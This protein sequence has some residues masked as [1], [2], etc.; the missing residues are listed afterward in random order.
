VGDSSVIGFSSCESCG[1]SDANAMYS[2]GHSYCFSCGKPTKANNGELVVIEKKSKDLI[3]TTPITKSTRGI[4]PDTFKFWK[5]HEGEFSGQRVHVANHYRKN[6]LVGQKIRMRGKDFRVL[7]NLE[8]LYGMWLWPKGS[9]KK[10]VITEGEL[11]A[12]SVSQVQANKWPVVSVPNGASGASR[13]IKDALDYLES[14]SEIVL[15]FDN[16][17]PGI[18]AAE[19][20]A[21]LFSPGKC[22]IAR[23]PEKDANDMLVSGKAAELTRAIWN[24]EAY[25]PHGIVTLADV[26]D[27]VLI[28]VEMGYSYPWQGLTDLTFGRRL[29]E[30]LFIGAGTGVGKTTFVLEMLNHDAHN[31]KLKTGIIPLEQT[32]KK[33]FQRLAGTLGNKK[34]HKPSD[35]S[36]DADTLRDTLALMNS[37]NIFVYDSKGS[38]DWDDIK[39]MIRYLALGAGCT[40]I[41]LDNI[42]GLRGASGEKN[43]D[44]ID[45]VSSDIA[46]LV[47]EL[48]IMLT[49]VSHLATPESGSHEEGARVKLR[50]FKGSRTLAAEAHNALGLERN[51]QDET[52]K[53]VTTVRV[54]KD[55]EMGEA[56]GQTIL[57]KY[58]HEI[59]RMI[60]IE[61][62]KEDIFD[63]EVDEF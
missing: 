6:K 27:D 26:Y 48:P 24:A 53:N 39:V 9:A 43:Q 37:D 50:E 59:G 23:L 4:T 34:F 44:F 49:V 31:L 38:R 21:K 10:I 32:P 19:E 41:Y 36:W 62:I 42:T 56:T 5:Y 14:F 7:G 54:L 30:S 22:K 12:L 20:C 60:E 46:S 15:L 47:I 29:N 57:L 52:K 16:D 1:S 2:D 25:K 8:P 63:S 55:R 18:K 33:F 13:S 51:Q 17:T 61:D 35:G 40:S 11:D 3:D 58:D 28:P 45:R